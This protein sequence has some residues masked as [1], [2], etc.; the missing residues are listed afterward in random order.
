VTAF[1]GAG[2]PRSNA[3]L[4]R[5]NHSQRR[6]TAWPMMWPMISSARGRQD[7]RARKCHPARRATRRNK[8]IEGGPKRLLIAEAA[9]KRRRRGTG[10]GS[11]LVSLVGIVDLMLSVQQ[12]TDRIF[13]PLTSAP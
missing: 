5:I 6:L 10:K 8:Q 13:Q 1:R 4:V 9:A 2:A 12:I 11:A 3:D 7:R